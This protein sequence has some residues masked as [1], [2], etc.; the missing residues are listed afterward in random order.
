MT[1]QKQVGAMALLVV[2]LGAF[3][4][5][6]PVVPE[7]ILYF[8]CV[9]CAGGI[10]TVPVA[11]V[12]VSYF[13]VSRGGVLVLIPNTPAQYWISLHDCSA[14]ANEWVCTPGAS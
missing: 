1:S 14:A 13:A 3:L 4:F 10:T 11:H 8:D 6:A 5:F 12:S 9:N 2:G 7:R